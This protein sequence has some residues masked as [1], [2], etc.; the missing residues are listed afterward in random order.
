MAPP[1]NKKSYSNKQMVGWFDPT[2]LVGTGIK[3]MVSG[4][5]GAYADKR[6]VQAALYRP[7]GKDPFHHYENEDEIW[8]DFVADLGDGFDSTYTI[9]RL[10]AEKELQLEGSP[11]PMPRGRIVILGGDQV[12]P[13]AKR[14]EYRDRFECPYRFAL[15]WTPAVAETAPHLFAIPG[16][17]DWYDG[18]TSFTRLFCQQRWIG[19]WKTAGGPSYF[20][21]RLPHTGALGHRQSSSRRFG[22]ERSIFSKLARLRTPRRPSSLHRRDSW[23]ATLRNGPN[24]PNLGV[25]EN[26]RRTTKRRQGRAYVTGDL[27]HY[28]RYRMPTRLPKDQRVAARVP[29]GRITFRSLHLD[30]GR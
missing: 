28:C 18:L 1:R 10:L 5:F 3:A 19:G 2:Q 23:V 24:Y 4:I 9:A 12:Y 6:E 25:F 7:D 14:E 20:R 27:P 15:P 26:N 8:F 13:T 17:H 30:D 16:N 22:P 29:Y 11:E 21:L